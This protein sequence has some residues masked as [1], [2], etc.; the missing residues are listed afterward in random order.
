MILF[1]H[2]N[3]WHHIWVE[4]DFELAVKVLRSR[5][6][7]IPWRIRAC[8]TKFALILSSLSLTVSHI[9]REGNSV[10]DMLAKSHTHN[11][12]IGGCLDFICDNLY[13]NMNKDYFHAAI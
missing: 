1:A 2:A 7:N 4:F 13:T 12:W 10:V 9:Y 6:R 11:T 3:D 8:W 5:G